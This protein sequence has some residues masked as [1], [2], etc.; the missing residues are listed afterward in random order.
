MVYIKR[1][2]MRGFKSFGPRQTSLTLD[3]GLTVITGP[4]G[5]GKSNVFDAI[6]FCLGQN[7]PKALRVGRL[8]GLVHDDGT[9]ATRGLTAR[10][11]LTFDNVD[12]RIPIDADLVT[13]S[14]EV[15]GGGESL[16]VLNGRRTTRAAIAEVLDL[17]L[18]SADGLNIVPQGMVTRLSDLLPDEKRRLIEQV[19]GVAQFDA[20]RAEA[21]RQLQEADL[22]L[23]VAMARIGE[24]RSRVQSLEAE[25]NDQ[26]RL[27]QLERDVGEAKSAMLA[28][29]LVAVRS[30]LAAERERALELEAQER[31][32][33]AKLQLLH[34]DIEHGEAERA[35]FVAEFVDEAGGRNVELQFDIGRLTSELARRQAELVEGQEAV[36][37]LEETLPL[38]RD[39]EARLSHESADVAQRVAAAA[40]RQ[41]A[42][43]RQRLRLEKEAR[44][45][46]RAR[47][48][49]QAR[50]V[51]ARAF[52]EKA[53]AEFL[54]G[55]QT[56]AAM[57]V[58][59]EAARAREGALKERVRAQQEKLDSFTATIRDLRQHLE[60]LTGVQTSRTETVRRL[61]ESLRDVQ[62]RRERLEEQVDQ[63]FSTLRRA[64]EALTRY[65][66]QRSIA[67]EL[68]VDELAL[69]RIRELA[70]SGGLRGFVGAA[71]ELV[72]YPPDYAAAVQAVFRTWA[73]AVVVRDMGSTLEVAQVVRRLRLGRI[74]VIPLSELQDFPRVRPPRIEGVQG[75]LAERVSAPPEFSGLV[76]FVFGDTVLASTARAAFI[77]ASRGMRAVTLA[78][79]LFEARSAA[80]ETGSGRTQASLAALVVGEA[81]LNS[82]RAA[83]SSLEKLI[84][85][86]R[87]NI[88]DLDKRTETVEREQ[89]RRTLVLERSK[90][91]RVAL[92]RFVI[93][94]RQLESQVRR[95]QRLVGRELEAAGR[96]RAKLEARLGAFSARVTH[97]QERIAALRAAVAPEVLAQS[98]QRL[99]TLED[100]L[101]ATDEQLRQ[102]ATELAR[103]GGEEEHNL[104]PGLTRLRQQIE[105]AQSEKAQRSLAIAEAAP[106]I[107]QLQNRVERLRADEARILETSRKTRPLLEQHE[108]KLHHLRERENSL[109]QAL[110]RGE[111][112]LMGLAKVIEHQ[113]DREQTL[114]GELTRLGFPE[115]P[116]AH[117][118][119]EELLRELTS[120]FEALRTGVNLLADRS[121]RE[122]YEGYKSLS[123]RR[124]QLERERGA[125]VRFID[126]VEGEKRR[127]F[128]Q[129]FERID[130]ELRGVFTRLTTGSAWLELENPDDLFAG[131]VFLMTQFPGKVA[132]ESSSVSGGEKTVTA[133]AFILAIQ[134]VYPSP[135]YLFDEIDA[136]L[137]P[138][139]AERLA[140]L[141]RERGDQSQMIVVTLKDTIVSRAP[142]VYGVYASEGLSQLVRYRPG[143]ELV[144]PYG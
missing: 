142:V 49:A 78:G 70:E 111:K 37:K 73:K 54:R 77:V 32:L 114:H 141:L 53:E 133:L 97:L 83:V 91:E 68:A 48:R 16:Y 113:S 31:D 87:E 134:A 52:L 100:A 69:L 76:N 13:I 9:E 121:Y 35:R 60:Q 18:I 115:P 126:E 125:I 30:G 40:E 24:I 71:E 127:V 27:A 80:F 123:E 46:T 67:E 96:Q 44:T 108:S 10:A 4:N 99:L 116:L 107:A 7:S 143:L 55:Q 86:R 144:V 81:S 39:A 20:K 74:K 122:I 120:E 101:R 131:G 41:T 90:A 6:A 57:E 124:N 38:L 5:S 14:R 64:A 110:A 1:L 106:Q 140:G 28:R 136:H 21:M 19:V 45:E 47:A 66:S 88:R 98:E 85:R 26:L 89:R 109:R 93:R 62:E 137:D 117:E 8:G 139:N 33:Q 12:R 11:T 2:E 50:S 3:R 92:E 118:G 94:Y 29:E 79:D 130:R 132:R 42:L 22:K 34:Q 23:Q 63:A 102:V 15:T 103:L 128:M 59:L 36:T 56:K 112:D 82:I 72:S 129:A 119:V 43:E 58:Q 51:T 105:M 75:S 25:R 138:L 135:F 17:A 61:E 84:S 104:R 95:R 65:E